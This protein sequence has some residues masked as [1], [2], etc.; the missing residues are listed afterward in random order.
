MRNTT[1][2]FISYFDAQ[3]ENHAFENSEIS[4]QANL[5]F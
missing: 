5:L 1:E 2:Q 4:I 3:F